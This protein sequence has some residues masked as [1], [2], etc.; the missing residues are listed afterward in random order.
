MD[1]YKQGRT[2]S[3]DHNRV[4]AMRRQALSRYNRP[5]P[6]SSIHPQFQL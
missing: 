1:G 3:Q 2:G 4:N 6:R 5:G